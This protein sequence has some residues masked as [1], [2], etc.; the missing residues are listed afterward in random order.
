MVDE[1]KFDNNDSPWEHYQRDPQE[2]IAW[3]EGKKGKERYSYPHVTG[4]GF[5]IREAFGPPAK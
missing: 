2:Y 5:E 1:L 4:T 3:A